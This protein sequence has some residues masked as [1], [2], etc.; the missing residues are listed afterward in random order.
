MRIESI[1]KQTLDDWIELLV[2]VLST[3]F[4][5]QQITHQIYY[6]NC[7]DDLFGHWL[8][9]QKFTLKSWRFS[10]ILIQSSSCL[11]FYFQYHIFS[12]NRILCEILHWKTVDILIMKNSIDKPLFIIQPHYCLS[13]SLL[14]G[15]AYIHVHVF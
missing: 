13:V 10:H 15:N 1:T 8:H 2:H 9:I 5:G 7:R 14:T 12:I 6:K 4:F 3:C 11:T